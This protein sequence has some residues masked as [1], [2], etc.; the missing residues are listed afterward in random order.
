[1]VAS[2]VYW[3]R[4]FATIKS[5]IDTMKFSNTIQLSPFYCNTEHKNV[6]MHIP[7][8]KITLIKVLRNVVDDFG[9]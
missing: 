9:T 4:I 2:R 8:R 7:G 5:T 1:M 6:F 3:Q